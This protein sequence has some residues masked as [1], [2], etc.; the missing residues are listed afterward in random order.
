MKF[1]TGRIAMSADIAKN[2][3]T[4]PSAEGTLGLTANFMERIAKGTNQR[5]LA[6]RCHLWHG[7]IAV[8]RSQ[9]VEPVCHRQRCKLR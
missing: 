6:N 7:I 2:V 1:R 9:N 8:Q 5:I 4:D 3:Q